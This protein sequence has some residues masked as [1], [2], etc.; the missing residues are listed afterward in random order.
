MRLTRRVAYG[1]TGVALALG[2]P[3]GL[4][5][6]RLSFGGEASLPWLDEELRR[7]TGI[8]AYVWVSTTV[9]FSAFAYQL[10]RIADSLLAL[11]RTD[12]LTGLGNTRVLDERL[13]E[14]L[15]RAVRYRSSLAVLMIDVDGLKSINDLHGHRGGDAALRHVAQAIRRTSRRIDVAVRWGG[16]E[17]A[18][19]AP[20]TDE[21]AALHLGERVRV[22]VEQLPSPLGFG[23]AV[24]VGVATR[25]GERGSGDAEALAAAADAALYAA[26]RRGGN[27][28]C[29][30]SYP[31]EEAGRPGAP[32]QENA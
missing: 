27:C 22:L 5:A 24:S 23:I 21:A 18:I 2:A 8:Y 4:L 15:A 28:V 14:E 13:R 10:G 7:H 16:D 12:A 32:S 6:V 3:A 25:H 30:A 9:V 19:L 1:W 11:S 29:A 26:K 31:V 17:F 20:N